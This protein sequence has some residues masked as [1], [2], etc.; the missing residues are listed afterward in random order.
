MKTLQYIGTFDLNLLNEQLRSAFPE[1]IIKDGYVVVEN[2]GMSYNSDS[3]LL[4]LNVPDNAD[5]NAI[6][7]IIDNHDATAR[8]YTTLNWQDVMQI[9]S[10]FLNMPDWATWTAQDAIDFITGDIL[11]GMSKTEIENWIDVNV[12]TLATAKDA[13][14]LVGGELVELRTITTKLAQAII[15]LRDLV[16]RRRV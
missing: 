7:E 9:R 8:L 1:W 2:Y 14:K 13:L 16:V 3:S 12:T 4:S 5:E 11:N 15:Y 6:L 10:D